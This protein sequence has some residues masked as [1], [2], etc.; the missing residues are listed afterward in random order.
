MKCTQTPTVCY[1]SE[2]PQHK[3]T[4]SLEAVAGIQALVHT[5]EPAAWTQQENNL[6]FIFYRYSK[7]QMVGI[8]CDLLNREKGSEIL[9]FR[10]Q[11]TNL[12]LLSEEVCEVREAEEF[13]ESI[14]NPPLA[15]GNVRSALPGDTSLHPL[16]ILGNK[17]LNE[18]EAVRRVLRERNL[19]FIICSSACKLFLLPWHEE[20]FN[21]TGYKLMR[22]QPVLVHVA[23]M[24]FSHVSLAFPKHAMSPTMNCYLYCLVTAS[25]GH[26]RV[27]RRFI[28]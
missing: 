17:H 11:L 21:S 23:S 3:H 18:E 7:L 5:W 2:I 19:Y 4:T 9:L 26:L 16:D 27:C 1:G 20:K 8:V 10:L 15:L 24:Q 22:C 28:H 12:L 6:L 14:S 25:N 13:H